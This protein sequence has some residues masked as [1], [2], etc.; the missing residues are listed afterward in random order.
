MR[1]S[2]KS[3]KVTKLVSQA[4]RVPKTDQ[5]SVGSQAE[6]AEVVAVE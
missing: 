4:A 2:N 6:P 3:L 5:N 1:K